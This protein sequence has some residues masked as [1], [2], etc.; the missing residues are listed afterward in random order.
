MQVAGFRIKDSGF[1][2]QDA[3]F[4]MLDAGFRIQDAGFRIWSLEV[5]DHVSERS[6]ICT[7]EVG[8]VFASVEGSTG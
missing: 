3:G 5:V 6:G 7:T 1:R 4:R 8:Q 2:M